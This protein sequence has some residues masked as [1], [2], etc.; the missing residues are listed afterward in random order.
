MRLLR[1]RHFVLPLAM[2]CTL[3]FT[4]SCASSMSHSPTEGSSSAGANLGDPQTCDAR[5]AAGART[6]VSAWNSHNRALL[7]DKLS[8]NALLDMSAKGQKALPPVV[9]GGYSSAQGSG[10]LEKTCITSR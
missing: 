6:F 3:I 2:L 8:V 7:F 9:R 4:A 1:H 5:S 10:D